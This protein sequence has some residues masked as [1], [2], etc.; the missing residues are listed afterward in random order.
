M[1]LLVLAAA[2]SLCSATDVTYDGRALVIDGKRRVL[3][4]GSIH[5][6][7]STPSVSSLINYSACIH[8]SLSHTHTYLHACMHIADWI[9]LMKKLY[10]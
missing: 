7:R 6:P 9:N 5:Y 1:V 3:V 8:L 4:S 10:I 2:A